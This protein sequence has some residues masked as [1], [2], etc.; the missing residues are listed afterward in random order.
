MLNNLNLDLYLAQKIEGKFLFFTVSVE[1]T[2]LDPYLAQEL[3]GNS[4]FK[5]YVEKLIW[6]H[7][8]PKNAVDFLFFKAI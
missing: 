5:I 2:N 3:K 8:W 6:I 7:I 4:N 1:K